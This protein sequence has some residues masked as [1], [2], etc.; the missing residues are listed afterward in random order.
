MPSFSYEPHHFTASDE[1]V[2]DKRLEPASVGRSL[3]LAVMLLA[4]LA[5][6]CLVRPAV[7]EVARVAAL[8]LGSSTSPVSGEID[9]GQI[10]SA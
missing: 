5:L 10:R 4:L 8:T 7:I 6:P 1:L 9:L 2:L 3:M